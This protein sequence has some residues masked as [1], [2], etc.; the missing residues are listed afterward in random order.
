MYHLYKVRLGGSSAVLYMS[1]WWFPRCPKRQESSVSW[2]AAMSCTDTSSGFYNC[3]R[4][5]Q[6]Q[7][8]SSPPLAF[9]SLP[10]PLGQGWGHG[11]RD[12]RLTTWVSL[13]WKRSRVSGKTRTKTP[14]LTLWSSSP[15]LINNQRCFSFIALTFESISCGSLTLHLCSVIK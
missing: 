13:G 6:Q 5:Q 12:E 1:F 4:T 2:V 9:P 14:T 7:S 11:I 15:P 10:F 8:T 3:H